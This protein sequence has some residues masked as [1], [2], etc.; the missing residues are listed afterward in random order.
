MLG[1]AAATYGASVSA[2]ARHD[3][4]TAS[5]LPAAP[6]A[7]PGRGWRFGPPL[8]TSARAASDRGGLAAVLGLRGADL[9]HRVEQVLVV[10]AHLRGEL[11]LLLLHAHRVRVVLHARA[12]E[13][14]VELAYLTLVLLELLGLLRARGVEAAQLLPRVR[15]ALVRLLQ[16]LGALLLQLLE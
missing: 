2:V 10:G 6:G 3:P 12:V 9:A 15:D 16:L 8:R 7:S 14:V 4:A 11:L 1:A 5:E 13:G